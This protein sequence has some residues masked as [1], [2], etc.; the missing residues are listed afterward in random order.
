MTAEQTPT[1]DRSY[2]ALVFKVGEK[3]FG[4]PLAAVVEVLEMGTT[5]TP[6]PGAPQW[7]EGMINHHGQVVP[8]VQ[9]GKFWTI[10]TESRSNQVILVDYENDRMGLI[11]DHVES[12]EEVRADGPSAGGRKHT[13]HRGS[14]LELVEV[15]QLVDL[16]NQGRS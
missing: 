13:W 2:R 7:L 1:D 12:V 6:V 15:E 4:L 9:M 11:V 16:I 8:V 10:P 3:H 14:L 5:P